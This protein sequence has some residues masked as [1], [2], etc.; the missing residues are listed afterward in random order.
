MKF[1]NYIINYYMTY[2]II[3]RSM[4]AGGGDFVKA[5]MDCFLPTM[6][7]FNEHLLI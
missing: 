1:K 2:T 7:S 6:S 4:K 5:S 3:C